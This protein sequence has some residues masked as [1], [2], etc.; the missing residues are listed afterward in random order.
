L[1]AVAAILPAYNE[2]RTIERIIKILRE[3]PE[4]NEIIVVSD[5]STDATTNVA[6]KA[7]AIVLELTSNKGKGA[8]MFAGAQFTSQEV[9]LFLDADLEGLL[10]EQVISIIAPVLKNEADMTIG[11]F[12]QGRPLTDWSQAVAPYLSGQRAIKR[13]LFLK[14]GLANS[15]Y[16]AEVR[17]THFAKENSW[18]V[19]EIPLVNVTHVIKEEKRGLWSGFFARLGMYRDIS[20]YYWQKEKRRPRFLRPATLFFILFLFLSLGV[21]DLLSIQTAKANSRH[22]SSFN[23][24]ASKQRILVLA[25]HPD[26]ETLATGGRICQATSQGDAVAVIFLTNG[27]SFRRSLKKQMGPIP[28]KPVDFLNFGYQRQ[29]EAEQALNILGVKKENIFFLG[30]PDK[31][32]E[33]IWRQYRVRGHPYTSLATR[34]N[35]VPYQ[36]TLSPGAPYIASAILQDLNKILTDFRPTEVYLPDTEDTHPDHR[37]AGVFGLAAILAAKQKQN[38]FR[39]QVYSYLVHAGSW[40]MAPLLSKNIPLVP[41]QKFLQRGSNWVKYPLAPLERKKK[42]MALR[43]Y[44]TQLQVIHTFLLNF[45]RPNEIFYKLTE[46]DISEM[47]EKYNPNN[48]KSLINKTSLIIKRG[49][50]SSEPFLLWFGRRDICYRAR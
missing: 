13:D 46:N 45:D 31:G 40:Q 32:L 28:P 12:K 23:L 26:D 10:P 21:Y 3:V 34:K 33:I 38:D 44:K 43:E 7:G 15:R 18:R 5:G 29:K 25:P 16:D 39:P 2:A 6:R 47:I 27:D 35:A 48:K 50:K 14:A 22:I 37:A 8:A 24:S 17:L 36:N 9:L 20:R 1:K 42:R 11:I 4:L 19:L 41:P 49:Y 30:Y